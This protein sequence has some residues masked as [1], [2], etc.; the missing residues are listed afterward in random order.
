[1]ELCDYGSTS[2]SSE[3]ECIL[4]LGL[5]M[6]RRRRKRKHKI[7]VRD[8]FKE[9]NGRGTFNLVR[10]MALA[11]EEMFFRYMRMSPSIFEKLLRLVGKRLTKQT[12]NYRHPV[13]PEQRLS[14]TL[15]HLA[16]GESHI[17]LSLQYRIGRQT[18]S[19]IIPETCEAIFE[20]L[21]PIYLK[22]PTTQQEWMEISNEFQTKWNLPHVIG[23]LDG[24]HIRIRCPNKTGSL[25]HNYKGFF[26]MVLMAVCDAK[27]KFVLFDFG[28]YG[29][30]NDSGVLL[31]SKMGEQLERN[32]M[33]IPDAITLPGCPCDPLPFFLVG[34]EIFPLKTYLMRPYP[35]SNLTESQAVY[36]YRHSR[37]RRVI[38][39]AFGIFCSRWRIFFTMI[40]AKVENIEKDVM[41]CI[42]LHNFL[43][44]TDNT[45]Y[46]PLG[47]IDHEDGNGEVIN[48]QWRKDISF[49]TNTAQ[50]ISP[51]RGRRYEGRALDMRDSLKSY[52]NSEVGSV[53]WQLDYVRR[54]K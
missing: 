35:G 6:S 14:V 40:N 43:K 17:S 31:N 51:L 53:P 49:A 8:V 2:S 33:H 52:V 27:Y 28:Q 54:T 38:E 32:E 4:L 47:Y 46:C 22:R 18:I 5:V 10:E 3:E 7:W 50:S 37:A 42:A 39:N 16:T 36:N 30:N 24:K 15:R 44:S 1:M 48:G 41:A 12:T 21:S 23:A 19:K 9:R 25:Y 34:D 13:P 29:S 20:V 26:S 11:D 45:N